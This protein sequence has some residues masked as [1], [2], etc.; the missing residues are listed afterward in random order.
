[1]FHI[2]KDPQYQFIVVMAFR[3]SGKSTIMNTVNILWSILGKPQK[4]FILIKSQSQEQA[5]NHF[6]NI[7]NELKYNDLLRN[8]FGPFTDDEALWNKMSLELEYHGSKIMSASKEQSVRGM[9]YGIIRPDLIICDDLED[10]S[11]KAESTECENLY[12][13]FMN[14][15]M[16]LGSKSTRIIVLGNLIGSDS[17]MVNLKKDIQEQKVEGIFRAYPLL[18]DERRILWPARFPDLEAVKKYKK[19]FIPQT[20]LRE[21]LLK[22][23][24]S[25]GNLEP[26]MFDIALADKFY[27]DD[28]KRLPSVQVPLI[29]HMREF[30]ISVPFDSSVFVLF[31]NDPKNNVYMYN[32]DL[33]EPNFH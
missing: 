25:K 12:Q 7:K 8:D 27:E 10:S 6:T 28:E 4:K 9:K 30:K 20:W 14:E 18:D 26:I 17:L 11:T 2:L 32:I 15:I 29:R 24:G 3:G 31:T 19:R 16:P 33:D 5:K 22:S 21:F 13:H 1:M 23:F